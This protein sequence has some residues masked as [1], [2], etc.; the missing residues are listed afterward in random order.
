MLEWWNVDVDMHEEILINRLVSGGIPLPF[1]QSLAEREKKLKFA[2]GTMKASFWFPLPY[3]PLWYKTLTKV[4][5]EISIDPS[6]SALLQG[7]HGPQKGVSIKPAWSNSMPN[8]SRI[9]VGSIGRRK[10]IQAE[11]PL[12]HY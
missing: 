8:L 9:I 6:F 5:K 1:V 11:G 7:A 2:S 12:F 4:L 10:G 3:H